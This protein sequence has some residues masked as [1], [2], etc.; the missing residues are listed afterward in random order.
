L[1]FNNKGSSHGT[2]CGGTFTLLL[3]VFM[4]FYTIRLIQRLGAPV[5]DNVTEVIKN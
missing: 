2:A 4:L 3:K 1:T 5:Y